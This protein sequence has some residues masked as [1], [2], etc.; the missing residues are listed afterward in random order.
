NTELAL[1]VGLGSSEPSGHVDF[2]A[3]G[4]RYQPGCPSVNT[5]IGDI[6]VGQSQ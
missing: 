2:Y 3:N 6:F 4:G 1:G 5:L